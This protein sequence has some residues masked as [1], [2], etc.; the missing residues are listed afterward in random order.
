MPT[1][2]SEHLPA[3]VAYLENTRLSPLTKKAYLHAL[4]LFILQVQDCPLDALSPAMLLEWH[5]S[6]AKSKLAYSTCNQKRAALKKFLDYVDQFEEGDQ[7]AK[8]LRALGRLQVPGDKKPKR[9]A[10]SLEEVN[11]LRL[12]ARAGLHVLSGGRDVAIL[13]FM[14]ATGARRA[15]VAS[16]LFDNVDLEERVATVVGK[17]DK[18]RLVVFDEECRESLHLWLQGRDERYPKREGVD[19]FFVTIDGYQMKPDAVS[20]IFRTCAM[21]A[22]LQGQVWPHLFRHTALSRLLDNGMAIQ[23]VAKLAG[24]AN[25]NTT[26]RYHHVE[27]ARLKEVYD[28]ATRG[29]RNAGGGPMPTT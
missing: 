5:G 20:A 4:R 6:L 7:A 1:K 11:L 24:H 15:E 12:L 18:E 22:G 8:L 26:A 19:T 3:F 17:G 14:W 21:E 13:H 9:E 27:E 23:D 16:L 29:D 28:R 10:Y 2:L 25:I